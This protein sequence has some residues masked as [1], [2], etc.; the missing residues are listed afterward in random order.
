MSQFHCRKCNTNIPLDREI[1]AIGKLTNFSYWCYTDDIYNLPC[2]P[3]H[4]KYRMRQIKQTDFKSH[5]IKWDYDDDTWQEVPI[6]TP[7]L[8]HLF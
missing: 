1:I 7:L 8:C 3:D 5:F 4:I 2:F 6:K